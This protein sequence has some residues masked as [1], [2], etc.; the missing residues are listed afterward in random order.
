V[1]ILEGHSLP[2]RFSGNFLSQGYDMPAIADQESFR[3]INRCLCLS[4]SYGSDQGMRLAQFRRVSGTTA[5]F[6]AAG[7][8]EEEPPRGNP[9]AAEHPLSARARSPARL[10]RGVTDA[11]SFEPLQSRDCI[12]LHRRVQLWFSRYASASRMLLCLHKERPVRE[13]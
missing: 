12:D 5:G 6:E 8:L 4:G 10:D 1:T 11:P 3:S 7:D 2:M 9:G 13:E